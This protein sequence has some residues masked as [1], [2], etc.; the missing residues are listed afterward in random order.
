VFSAAPKV[1]I[2]SVASAGI[3]PLPERIRYRLSQLL[4]M[5]Y[6]VNT[7]FLSFS[8][9]SVFKE[10]KCLMAEKISLSN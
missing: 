8:A 1:Q 5:P 9:F 6:T 3:S 4:P 7:L 2:C 10:R